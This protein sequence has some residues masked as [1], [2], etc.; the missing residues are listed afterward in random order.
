[1]VTIMLNVHAYDAESREDRD[2]IPAVLAAAFC[3]VTSLSTSSEDLPPGIHSANYQPLE[4]PLS[5]VCAG[6]VNS[7][8]E[9][10]LE[11][12]KSG[13]PNAIVGSEEVVPNLT[14][15]SRLWSLPLPRHMRRPVILT[16]KKPFA[17][18][19]Q[20]SGA[21]HLGLLMAIIAMSKERPNA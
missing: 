2:A 9:G 18:H 1:M 15:R 20:T 3:A 8:G 17:K 6:A 10:A 21:S 5:I 12:I 19:C 11:R 16:S 4:H 7:S 13:D 14:E